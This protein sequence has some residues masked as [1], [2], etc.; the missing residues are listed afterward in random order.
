MGPAGIILAAPATGQG[1]TTVTLGLLR[2]LARKGVRA[3]PA[4]V[5]P[6]FIDPAFHARA[7]GR[8]GVNLDDWAMQDGTLA[9]VLAG[10]GKDADLIFCEGVMGL[11][12]GAP[13]GGGSTADIA[14]RTGWPVILVVDA[15]AQGQSIAALLHGFASWQPDVQVVGCI[16][17]RIG[18]EGHLELVARAVAPL[19]IP[20]LGALPYSPQISL[21]E[22]HLGLVQASETP[23][24]EKLLDTLADLVARHLDLDGLVALARPADVLRSTS[25]TGLALPPPG[26]RV[27]V[28]RDAAFAF[29]YTHILD[30]WHRAGAEVVPFS[31]LADEPPERSADAVFLPGGYP[32]LHAGRIA[33]AETFLAGLRKAAETGSFVYGE[34]GGFMVLGDRLTD[35]DGK[36]HAMAGLLPVATSFAEPV[37]TIGYR[38]ATLVSDLP[39]GPA[40][41]VFAAHEFHQSRQVDAV[42]ASP[43][44][45]ATDGAAASPRPMGCRAGSVAGSYLHLIAQVAV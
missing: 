45:H 27:A 42:A 7:A 18:G 16:L 22:R 28:A 44:F 10:T 3:A 30:D 15:S 38:R 25:E 33:A 13:G 41:S 39:F 36:D 23:A 5:G 6:D 43:L 11:F 4:K 20:L 12:D 2:A 26:S 40:G 9:S 31:P 14:R 37:L 32:E 17:N 21:P 8:P 29:A 35:A 19:G 1:K 24:L 34:C